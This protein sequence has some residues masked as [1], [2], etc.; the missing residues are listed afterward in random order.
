LIYE[1]RFT[2]GSGDGCE[3]LLYQQHIEQRGI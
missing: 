2:Y 3:Y 1:T